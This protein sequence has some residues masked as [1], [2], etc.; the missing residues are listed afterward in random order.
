MVTFIYSTDPQ[1][2]RE[3]STINIPLFIIITLDLWTDRPA[4]QFG[5]FWLPDTQSHSHTFM[6]TSQRTCTHG[7]KHI[8]GQNLDKNRVKANGVR[9][10]FMNNV[11]KIN[12]WVFTSQQHHSCAQRQCT[13]VMLFNPRILLIQK[14]NIDNEAVSD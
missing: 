1:I 12:K 8:S 3:S 6:Q 4:Q 5:Q 10:S 7:N 14:D 11:Y 2:S 13:T 9:S